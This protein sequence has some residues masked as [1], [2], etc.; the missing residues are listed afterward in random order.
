MLPHQST[1]HKNTGSSQ[2]CVEAT[3]RTDGKDYCPLAVALVLVVCEKDI[4][5]PY[6]M[7][8]K[9]QIGLSER[10]VFICDPT[11]ASQWTST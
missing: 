7:C 1:R 2:F 11:S 8:I 5:A 4:T 6:V 3:D 9:H 10:L